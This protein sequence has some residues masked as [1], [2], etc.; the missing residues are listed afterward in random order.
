MKKT[1]LEQFNNVFKADNTVK[2]CGRTECKKLI[3]LANTLEPSVEH[4]NVKTGQMEI[5]KIINLRDKI[6]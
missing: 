2:A 6:R 4:G 3:N 5:E 1:F